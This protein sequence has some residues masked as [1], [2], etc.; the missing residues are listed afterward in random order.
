MMSFRSSSLA[1]FTRRLTGSSSESRSMRISRGPSELEAETAF[2]RIDL[3]RR[4]ADV[5]EGPRRRHPSRSR[6]APLRIHCSGCARDGRDPPNGA[7][8]IRASSRA[9]VSL[10]RPHKKPSPPVRSM[11]AKEWPPMPD[12][13]VE[14]APARFWGQRVHRFVQQYGNVYGFRR[15]HGSIGIHWFVS[16]CCKSIA[17]PAAGVFRLHVINSVS[18]D[19]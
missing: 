5:D 13:A 2:R 9:C 4:D 6:P 14:I 18:G 3:E 11:M 12:R 7:R 8:R 1:R 16:S 19:S 17:A 10:S 15:R